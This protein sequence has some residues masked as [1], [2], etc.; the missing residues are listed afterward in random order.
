MDESKIIKEME[1]ESV[2][3]VNKIVEPPRPPGFGRCS[4]C[5]KFVYQRTEFGKELILCSGYFGRENLFSL[6]PCREDPIAECSAFFP[7]GQMDLPQMAR[8][9]TLIDPNK[10]SIGF[11]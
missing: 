4:K 7:A 11:K 10:N 3:I 6:K 1:K 2:G 8:I 9:A 5:D